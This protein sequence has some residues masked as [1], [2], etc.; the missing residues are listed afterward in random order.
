VKLG[1]YSRGG[2]TRGDNQAL[3][4]D[5]GQADKAIPCGIVN[6]DSGALF[7]GF[8]RSGKTSDFIVDNL[9]CWWHSCSNITTS[10]SWP[11]LVKILSR[12]LNLMSDAKKA[13]RGIKSSA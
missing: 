13:A 4:H 8:G 11:L 9:N 5:M 12:E 7:L 10:G 2:Q 6:E 3:D 1:E